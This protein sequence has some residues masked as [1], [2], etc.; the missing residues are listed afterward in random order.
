MKVITNEEI[1]AKRKKLA[2]ILAPA[3][4]F[5]LLGGLLTNFLSLRDET[6]SSTYFYATLLL[7]LL[8]FTASSISSGLVTRWVREPRADQILSDSL[9]KFDNR[10]I[11]LNYTTSAAPHILIAQNKVYAILTKPQGGGIHVAGKRW[12]RDFSLGRVFRFFAEESLG[13][14]TLEAQHNAERVQKL[15]AKHLPEGTEVPVEPVVLFTDPKV[16][17][18]VRDSEV[19]VMKSKEFK[20]FVR[21]QTK[22]RAIPAEIRQQLVQLLGL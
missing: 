1:I 4:L 6:I 14:P 19:A 13:N 7:L 21:E 16:S 22:G 12:K 9:K 5:L 20:T 17:L 10:H 8:G 2:N 3:A 11:L 18:T 15:I